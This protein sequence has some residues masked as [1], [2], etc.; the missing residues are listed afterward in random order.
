L[1][2]SVKPVH[3]PNSPKS[4]RF[5]RPKRLKLETVKLD[6]ETSKRVD[7][8]VASVKDPDLKACL[9]RLFIKQSQRALIEDE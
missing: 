4:Q 5:H 8:T 1:N 2:F 9:K 7:Q 6:E 3:S